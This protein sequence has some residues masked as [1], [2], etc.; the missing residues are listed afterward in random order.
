MTVKF[1]HDYE[2]DKLN[3]TLE[4]NIVCNRKYDRENQNPKVVIVYEQGI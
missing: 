4:H 2:Q 1:N 3:Y